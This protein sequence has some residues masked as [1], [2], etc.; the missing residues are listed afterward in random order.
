MR[1]TVKRAFICD[2]VYEQDA[3]RTA[4]VRSGDGSE[5]FLARC[6]PLQRA[7]GHSHAK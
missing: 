1:R 2:V 5:P 4:V 3:H 6:I 7:Q